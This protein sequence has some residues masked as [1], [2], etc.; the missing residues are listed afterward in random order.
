MFGLA[1]QEM[2]ENTFFTPEDPAPGK[3]QAGQWSSLPTTPLPFKAKDRSLRN[4]IG[5]GGKPM[6][7][8]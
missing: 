4:T 2:N 7:K 5:G 6:K 8:R 1:H 3:S